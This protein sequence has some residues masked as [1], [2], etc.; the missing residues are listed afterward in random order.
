MR[1]S[2]AARTWNLELGGGRLGFVKDVTVSI[3][4]DVNT[5]TNR[6][7]KDSQRREN[8]SMATKVTCNFE[9]YVSFD[10]LFRLRLQAP[11]RNVD[12]C[13]DYYILHPFGLRPCL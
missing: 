13:P 9:C 3:M 1:Y 11:V 8:R 7:S 12:L 5:V 2:T 6:Q 4:R 10:E